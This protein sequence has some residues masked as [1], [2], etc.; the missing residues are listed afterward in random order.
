MAFDEA[1]AARIRDE[2]IP[3]AAFEERKM[4]GGLAF[5]VNTHMACGI[6][7]DDLMVRVG[8]QGHAAALARGAREM[9]L[10]G[11]PMRGMVT[12]P[13]EALEDDVLASWVREAVA[14]AQSEA[15]KPPKPPRK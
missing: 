7:G 1:L 2:L 4:F 9:E 8:K 6:M 5:L 11:R 12:V 14:F 10:T 15:P 13:G 3:Q